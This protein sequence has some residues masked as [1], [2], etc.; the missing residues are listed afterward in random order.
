MSKM[1]RGAN[2]VEAETIRKERLYGVE[3]DDGLYTLAIANMIIR[4]DGKS[5]IIK[6]DCFDAKIVKE[7]K[8]RNINVGLINP[9]YSLKGGKA[10]LEF[11]EQLLDILAA[12]GTG[13]VVVPMSCAIGTKFKDVRE[14]LFKKHTLKA[15]FS[16][17][18][19]I[20]YPT[21]TNPCVMVWQAHAPHDAK[22]ETFFGYCKNDGYVKR[23]KLGRIDCYGRWAG[24]L[25]EW[26]KTYRNRD[27]VDGLSARAYVQHNDEWLCEAYMKTD[28]SALT[29]ADFQ[30][31]VNDYLAYLVKTGEV[32]ES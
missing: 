17:P 29:Q 32:N 10:E 27:A 22:Q 31:T 15:V 25:A 2:P 3:Q 16:M 30:N 21:G 28:Y 6:G 1:F 23:K 4:Q 11:V 18:D 26:L 14:R 12:G 13:V 5:N 9:P 20:F 7:L 24:I 19:D 8:T